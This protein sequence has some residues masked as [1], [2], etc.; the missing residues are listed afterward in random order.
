MN[1][2]KAISLVPI[3]ENAAV[4]RTIRVLLTDSNHPVTPSAVRMLK[5]SDEYNF[6][7]VGI[8]SSAD[9][10]GSLWTDQFYNVPDPQDSNYINSLLEICKKEK[11]DVIIPWSNIDAVAISSSEKLLKRRHIKI[12][13]DS[14][15]KCKMLSDKAQLYEALKQSDI[16]LP[17]YELVSNIEE[18]EN[19]AAILGYPKQTVVVKPRNFSGGKGF[20][21]L[22]ERNDIITK[23][24]NK[25]MPLGAFILIL[26]S[27]DLVKQ[28]NLE[29]MV[30]ETL[31]GED[32]SVD[33]LSRLGKPIFVV[34]RKRLVDIGGVSQV[35]ETTYDPKVDSIV[36]KIISY[37]DITYN[38]NIQLRYRKGKVGVPY[39]YDVN[40]RISGTI[41]ANAYVGIDLLIYGIYLALGLPI[42]LIKS[43]KKARMV[44]CWS[45]YLEYFDELFPV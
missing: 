34:Q 35:G 12:V 9:T 4:K 31:T 33:T 10:Y 45:E 14:G 32:Y 41:V 21:V 38:C 39:V 17:K 13:C 6:Y 18:L 40:P 42:P 37:F 29:Y 2:R 19:A 27:L 15:K 5:N 26:K 30:M 44:R 24:I 8:D 20:C 1:K 36:R 43:Y 22:S 3:S 25:Q 16:P 23:N 11:I 7:V 28:R